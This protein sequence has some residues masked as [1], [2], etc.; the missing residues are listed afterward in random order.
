MMRGTIKKKSKSNEERL[1]IV[2]TAAH[3]ILQNTHAACYKTIKYKSPTSFLAGA[4]DY[5]PQTL[6]KFLNIL[7]K[8]HKK[9]RTETNLKKLENRMLAA[10]HVLV[11]FIRPNSFISPISE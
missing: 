7:I 1:R 10:A 8:T 4:E 9:V 6:K 3:I 2:E 5:V 11:S